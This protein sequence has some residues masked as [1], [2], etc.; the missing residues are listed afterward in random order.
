MTD[1]DRLNRGAEFLPE[2]DDDT[3]PTL[4][5]GG[6]HVYVY[7]ATTGKLVISV[8]TESVEPLLLPALPIEINVMDEVV[9]VGEVNE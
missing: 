3:T 5:I 7:F 9:Y 1:Y 8:D 2:V 6:V 4:V